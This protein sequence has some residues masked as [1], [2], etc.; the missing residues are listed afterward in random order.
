MKNSREHQ[1]FDTFKALPRVHLMHSIC[2]FEAREV[3]N[4]TLQTLH[5]SEL[6]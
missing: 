5:K 3:S 6:K 4:P 2:R 1:L